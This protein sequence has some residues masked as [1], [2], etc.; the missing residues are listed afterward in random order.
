[1]RHRALLLLAAATL[2]AAGC[3]PFVR[4]NDSVRVLVF[5]I[6]AGK[7]AAGRDNLGD[8]ARLVRSTNAEI[9][10]L[11]EIDRGT[12][13][14]GNVDQL[15][16][17]A[18]LTGY[19]ATFG[20]SLDYDGGQYGV[21]A[22]SRRGFVYSDTVH[23]PVMPLQA[24]AGGSHEPR[25]ALVT[26]A[27]TREGRLQAVTTHLDASAD[28]SYRLQESE[29]LLNLVRARASAITPLIV[30]GDLNAEPASA[31]IQKLRQAG[32]RDAWAEC[33][34]GEGLTYPADRPVKRIDYLFL[35]A[36]LRCTAAEVIDTRI[37]DH[38]PL[39]VTLVDTGAVQ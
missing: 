5:N 36:S 29:E 32:L 22:L 10:L 18:D 30:G 24:R 39:L 35:T 37:S 2:Y 34:Q 9:V 12:T 26:S 4:K 27:V 14:S 20:R 7:D 21:A 28:E 15:Q 3:M 19:H 25:V 23:L 6:H 13:R 8:V 11:Q 16:T 38:C 33:G 1:M 17:L 31:T